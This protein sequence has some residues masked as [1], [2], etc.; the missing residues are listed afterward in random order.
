VEVRGKEKAQ[1]Q[2]RVPGFLDRDCGSMPPAPCG[3]MHLN[4][5]NGQFCVPWVLV[6]SYLGTLPTGDAMEERPRSQ[7]H[8][9]TNTWI[10]RDRAAGA[11]DLEPSPQHRAAASRTVQR[12]PALQR[13]CW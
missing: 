8:A 5:Q 4:Q 9:A 11:A 2:S 10:A 12:R 1:A 13:R 6:R 3:R 7:T